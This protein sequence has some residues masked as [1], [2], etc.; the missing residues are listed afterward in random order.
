MWLFYLGFLFWNMATW[1]GLIVLCLLPVDAVH[2]AEI[3]SEI[4]LSLAWVA[5]QWPASLPCPPV[6]AV[7]MPLTTNS[8]DDLRGAFL[9]HTPKHF[10]SPLCADECRAFSPISVSNE[11]PSSL[12]RWRGTSKAAGWEPRLRA[13]SHGSSA[14]FCPGAW[15]RAATSEHTQTGPWHMA[16]RGRDGSPNPLP[17][18]L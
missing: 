11:P 12:S 18:G 14:A 6:E 3:I 1:N 8:S 9:L 13:G 16:F 17:A 4:L 2:I 5:S 15:R 10:S 7:T